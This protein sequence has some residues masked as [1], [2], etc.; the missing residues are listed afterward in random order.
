M[1]SFPFYTLYPGGGRIATPVLFLAL[2]G[3]AIVDNRLRSPLRNI[4]V[5]VF[6]ASVAVGHYGTAWVVMIAL[7]VSITVFYALR[8]ADTLTTEGWSEFRP[9]FLA[10]EAR[11]FSKVLTP[12]AIGFYIVFALGW[13][14]YTGLG[15]KFSTLPNHVINGITSLLYGTGRVGGAAIRSATKNY[16]S[17]AVSTS[18]LF[19]ILFGA[20][21]V[22]GVAFVLWERVTTEERRV[23]DEYLALGTGFLTIL[24]AAFL[25]FSTGFNTARVMMIVFTF[26]APFA[27]FGIIGLGDRGR[28]LLPAV[29]DTRA[30]SGVKL[31]LAGIAVLLSV[32]LLLNA[33]V[34]SATVTNDFAPSNVVTQEQLQESEDPIERSRATF[35]TACIVET[36]SWV[37]GNAGPAQPLYG[38]DLAVAQ[39]DYFRGQITESTGS[40]PAG[41][42]YQSLWT[43]R[44]G[45]NASALLVT[46]P[47][48]ADTGGVFVREKYNWTAYGELSSQF[49]DS[50]RIYN[51]EGTVVY[52]TQGKTNTTEVASR[53]FREG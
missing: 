31:P 27:V 39:V 50:H 13:Y 19:Y 29:R 44:N 45:T 7:V 14:L 42:R 15:G 48:N 41:A 28:S 34:V 23:T 9:S 20:L 26:T 51:G 4:L 25:P 53:E 33:G 10:N 18:R 32:F 40:V 38:D 36:H 47:H 17:T 1:F 11:S 22:V 6:G 24:G 43:A 8:I 49:T 37:F 35:C 30:E 21:M 46:L 5:L 2:M 3:L 16:G 52:L 12:S